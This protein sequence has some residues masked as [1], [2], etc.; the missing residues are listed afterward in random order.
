M[1]MKKK[2]ESELLSDEMRGEMETYGLYD[3]VKI[4]IYEEK[5]QCEKYLEDIVSKDIPRRITDIRR[6]RYGFAFRGGVINLYGKIKHKLTYIKG[7]DGKLK[8]GELYD[9]DAY[10]RKQDDPNRKDLKDM[11][12][13][14]AYRYFDLMRGFIEEIGITKFEIEKLTLKERIKRAAVE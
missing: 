3:T 1:R 9:L 7:K 2:S 13:E 11:T 5:E 12:F 4:G 8:Y 6:M 14:E 10:F